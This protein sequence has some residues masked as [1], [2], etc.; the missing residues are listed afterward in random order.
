M[1]KLND[2]AHKTVSPDAL[3]TECTFLLSFPNQTQEHKKLPLKRLDYT[4]WVKKGHVT[5][6][7]MEVCKYKKPV[8][9]RGGLIELFANF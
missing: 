7:T 9:M 3:S 4:G 2:Q 6:Y 1:I 8:C 5:E